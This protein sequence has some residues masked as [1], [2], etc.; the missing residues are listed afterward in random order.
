MT[1]T[2]YDE[3]SKYLKYLNVMQKSSTILI[4]ELAQQILAKRMSD[5][6]VSLVS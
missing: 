4:P 3:F 6:I 2:H 5:H 1:M